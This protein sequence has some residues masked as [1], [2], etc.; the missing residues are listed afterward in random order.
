MPGAI[1]DGFSKI[2]CDGLRKKKYCVSFHFFIFI[3]FESQ[4]QQQ[5]QQQ[6]QYF[7]MVIANSPTSS[8]DDE[9]IISSDSE[10]TIAKKAI[11]MPL[12]GWF[13]TV[14]RIS[15][16]MYGASTKVSQTRGVIG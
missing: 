10:P 7:T 1:F 4:Q 6:Q 9:S 2:N 14:K 16:H 3:R 8:S 12:D 13:A 5:Q 11:Y 15:N